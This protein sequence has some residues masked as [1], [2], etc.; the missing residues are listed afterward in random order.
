MKHVNRQRRSKTRT[1]TTT[2]NIHKNRL[3]VY[4]SIRQTWYRSLELRTQSMR[5][6]CRSLLDSKQSPTLILSA[7]YFMLLPISLSRDTSYQA[8]CIFFLSISLAFNFLSLTLLLSLSFYHSI[9]HSFF[10][11]FPFT[12]SFCSFGFFAP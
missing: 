3:A 11:F 1:T 6:I 2:L 8:H 9:P 4:I 10:D 7:L 12:T 5:K